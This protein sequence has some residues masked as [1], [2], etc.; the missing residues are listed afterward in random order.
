[1]GKITQNR[2]AQKTGQKRTN[3][4]RFLIRTGEGAHEE[5]SRFSDKKRGAIGTSRSKT[6]EKTED[7]FTKTARTGSEFFLK[8]GK[9]AGAKDE[10]C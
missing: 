1:M 6:G 9:N 3:S 10:N 4:R 7:F 2:K 5:K 8:K